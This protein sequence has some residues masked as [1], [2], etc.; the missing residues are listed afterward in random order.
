[1]YHA[2]PGLLLWAVVLV[3]FLYSVSLQCHFGLLGVSDATG[4]STVFLLV[5]LERPEEASSG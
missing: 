5:L 2:N 4:V 1:M 3:R